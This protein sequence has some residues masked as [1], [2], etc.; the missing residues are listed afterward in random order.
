M[1]KIN[2]L[3]ITLFFGFLMAQET[4]IP[5][6]FHNIVQKDGKIGVEYQGK[7]YPAVEPDD[8]PFTYQKIV[9]PE[10]KSWEHGVILN[11]KNPA[12][13]G[14]LY[15]GLIDE[16]SRY[17]MPVYSK[18]DVKI[19]QGKAKIKLD[20]LRGKYDFQAWEQTGKMKLGYRILDDR[21]RIVSDNRLNVKYENGTFVPSVTMVEGPFLSMPSPEGITIF[22]RLDKDVETYVE[23]NGKKFKPEKRGINYI[24]TITGL[25]PDQKYHYTIIYDDWEEKYTFKTAPEEGYR[26]KFTFAYASDSRNAKGGG[27][28]NIYGTNA[29]I[30]K[31]MSIAADKEGADFFLFTGDM[32]NGYLQHADQ[33]RLQ[34]HNFKSSVKYF[35]MYRPMYLGMGN[36]EALSTAFHK[37]D[38]KSSAAWK[39]YISVDRFPFKNNSGE[40]LFSYE[41]ELP[42]NGPDSEDGASYDPDKKTLDF[43]CYHET[44]YSF[45][46]GNV[47]IIVLNSNYWYTTNPEY[48]PMVG[49]NVHGYVMDMQLKWLGETIK[50]MEKNKK[51]D[52]ILVTIHTPAF[53]NAGHSGDDMWYGGNND[54]RPYVGGKP[55]EKGIIERRDELLDIL[56][57]YSKKFRALLTGDEH[58]YT[59]LVVTN[60]TP[61]YPQDWK[62]KKLSFSR[63]F[64]QITNGAAGAPYYALEKLPWT[65]FVKKFSTQNALM[66]F[67][68]EGK[69]IKV[70]VFNPDTFEPIETF[71]LN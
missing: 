31:R 21:G 37:H 64:V 40:Y 65:N 27:E 67:E 63:P 44:V 9:T 43:P 3:L 13:K 29:Y 51:I 66:I 36:H 42:S 34:Y 50:A 46:Y 20:K 47:G 7:F 55:V 35:T 25:K 4:E 24:A 10:I 6:S 49:G 52:H 59:R 14:T 16:T 57:N 15:Y 28:R 70:R 69:N 8:P 33:Q 58:N 11:F 19:S 60:E 1:K 61:I 26:G 30:L 32:I 53:P 12:F 23:V 54:I 48:I 62:G 68:V 2:A 45:T 56:V 38:S 41:F 18:W 71:N 22:Y 39:R 17:K 5:K